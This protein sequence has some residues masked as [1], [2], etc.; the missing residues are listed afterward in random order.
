MLNII[1]LYYIVSENMEEKMS[2]THS[3]SLFTQISDIFLF[4]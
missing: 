4:R 1:H 2:G 3:M